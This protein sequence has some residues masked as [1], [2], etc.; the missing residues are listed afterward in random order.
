M[1][2]LYAMRENRNV[3]GFEEDTKGILHPVLSN[4]PDDTGFREYRLAKKYIARNV[5]VY[6]L[7]VYR[8]QI[9]E[10]SDYLI[11]DPQTGE[12]FVRSKDKFEQQFE[13]V[14]R[15]GTDHSGNQWATYRSSKR[16]WAI[17][18]GQDLTVVAPFIFTKYTIR[19]GEY[20]I[21]DEAGSVGCLNAEA[22]R[23]T[24]EPM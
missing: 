14:C 12:E 4:I 11:I 10:L 21:V 13:L 2:C 7:H 22:F 24:Y 3:N 18:A 17:Q 19:K 20:L 23:A 9:A 1:D 8:D 5:S 6:D 16:F 15:N